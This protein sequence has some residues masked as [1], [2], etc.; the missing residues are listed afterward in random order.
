MLAEGLK[1]SSRQVF[2]IEVINLLY[3]N[4]LIYKFFSSYFGLKSMVCYHSRISIKA[5]TS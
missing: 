1:I 4:F 3:T 5:S 2:E